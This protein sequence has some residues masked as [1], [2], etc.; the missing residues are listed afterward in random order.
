MITRSKR[1][2]TASSK[3]TT[4]EPLSIE[5]AV[6]SLDGFE[7]AKFDETVELSVSLG[8]DP[9]QSSLA[10]RG[11]VNLPHGSGKDVK[12]LVFTQTP[13]DALAA[14]ADYAGLEDLIKKVQDGWLDFDVA[15][16]TTTAMKE[17]RSVARVLGPRGLMPTPKAGTVTDD[18]ATA[19]NAVKAGRVEF[20]M[21]KTG[22]MAVVVGKRSFSSDQLVENT[23]A[24]LRAVDESR[25]EGFK[26]RFIK[27]LH[28]SSTM[29]PSL[30]VETNI[31]N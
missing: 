3:I 12:V 14:G 11:T 26:G 16:S 6:K 29:S 13:E 5:L 27:T 2:T 4:S 30:A 21:D 22:A 10:V 23:Q 15:L 25:P 20:K 28:L 9:K 7:K 19:I 18:L 31:S 17:V 1:Y 8:V 24:A